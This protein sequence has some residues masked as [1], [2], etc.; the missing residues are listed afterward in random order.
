MNFGVL[1]S[2]SF[3][4]EKGQYKN[5]RDAEGNMQYKRLRNKVQR[6]CRKARNNW[7]EGMCEEI[8]SLFEI[9]KV[10]AAHRE[11][12]EHF[13]KRRNNANIEMKTKKR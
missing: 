9:G 1:A 13:R 11:I 10:D 8:E 4:I 6:R 7:I 12:R 2:V 3:A 5:A